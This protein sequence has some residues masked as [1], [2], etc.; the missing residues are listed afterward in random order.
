MREL[1]RLLHQPSA[2]TRP[3]KV[4]SSAASFPEAIPGG[5]WGQMTTAFQQRF[6]V[7]TPHFLNLKT[8]G[9]CCR[10]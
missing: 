1:G 8:A 6:P 3:G 9:V 10:K 4:S 2:Q 7:T 5:V